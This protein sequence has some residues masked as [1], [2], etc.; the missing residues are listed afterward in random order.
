MTWEQLQKRNEM[1]NKIPLKGKEYR[2]VF[3]R[4]K[5]FR[6]LYPEGSIETEIISLQDGVVVMKATARDDGGRILGTGLA[7]E[8]EGSSNVNR[9]SYIENCETSAVGRALG[10]VGIGID[11]SIASAEEVINATI[12]ASEEKPKPKPKEPAKSH[13]CEYCGKEID[14][15]TARWSSENFKGHFFCSQEHRNARADA[16]LEKK[17]S[18]GV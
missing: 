3:Q 11:M 15:E 12:Q 14:E 13:T 10:F 7:Y 5:A 6:M 16:Y 2:E 9:T 18:A 17:R 1:I 8:K 4:V